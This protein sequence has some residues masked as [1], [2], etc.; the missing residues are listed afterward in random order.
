MI[1]IPDEIIKNEDMTDLEFTVYCYIKDLCWNKEL[2]PRLVLTNMVLHDMY[3]DFPNISR[4]IRNEISSALSS[5]INK[6]IIRGKIFSGGMI[7]VEVASL[8]CPNYYTVV[9]NAEINTIIRNKKNNCHTLFRFYCKLLST[10]NNTKIGKLPEYALAAM[11]NMPR[12]TV[13]RYITTLED[14]GILYVYRGWDDGVH[15]AYGREADKKAVFAY[16]IKQTVAREKHMFQ[17]EFEL[18]EFNA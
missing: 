9:N 17:G 11:F 3:D 7:E 18:I 8:E 6:G 16:G 1:L 2:L 5:L 13:G 10:Y 14:L 12:S 4:K 15:I